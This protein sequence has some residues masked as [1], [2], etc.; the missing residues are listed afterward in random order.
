MCA[1]SVPL[2]GCAQ[3]HGAIRCCGLM[4]NREGSCSPPWP[5][6]EAHGHYPILRRSG[7]LQGG[8]SGHAAGARKLLDMLTQLHSQLK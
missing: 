8:C 4:L 1:G 3:P 2:L 6:T 5:G 7:P